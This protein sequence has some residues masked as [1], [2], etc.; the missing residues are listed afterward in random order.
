MESLTGN[1]AFNDSLEPDQFCV[2]ILYLLVNIFVSG[3]GTILMS[4]PHLPRAFSRSVLA[5]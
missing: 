5:L 4:Q 1:S 3:V 2:G